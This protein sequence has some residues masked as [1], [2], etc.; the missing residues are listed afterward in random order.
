MRGDTA[1]VGG[2]SRAPEGDQFGSRL[3]L[4]PLL[5]GVGFADGLQHSLQVLRL[6]VA[7]QLGHFEISGLPTQVSVVTGA[8]ACALPECC[9]RTMPQGGRLGLCPSRLPR[10]RH[11]R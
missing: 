1:C 7:G 9:R 2:V 6:P 11:G 8:G 5:K 4:L 10:Y 3:R